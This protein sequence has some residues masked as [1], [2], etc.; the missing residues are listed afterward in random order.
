MSVYS[1]EAKSVL[2]KWGDV[3]ATDS[4]SG[5]S[6]GKVPLVWPGLSSLRK[7]TL[8]ATWRKTRT[9]RPVKACRDITDGDCLG[10]G[11][12]SRRLRAL[13]ALPSDLGLTSST[14]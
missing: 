4:R 2:G 6:P 8:E 10:V 11:E 5:S 1:A 13:A 12:M 14:L 7:N 3:K 9:K